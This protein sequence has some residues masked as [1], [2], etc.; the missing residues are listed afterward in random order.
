VSVYF[1]GSWLA[2]VTAAVLLLT[3]ARR[4]GIHLSVSV[5]QQQRPYI[6]V[7]P[8]L[9]YSPL[10]VGLGLPQSP[11]DPSMVMLP[12]ASE[13]PGLIQLNEKWYT[14][15]RSGKGEREET[16]ALLSILQSDEIEDWALQ[17]KFFSGCRQLGIVLEPALIDLFFSIP[18]IDD[19]LDVLLRIGRATKGVLG[20]SL[21][22]LL[23]T[24]EERQELLKTTL[25]PWIVR[26]ENDRLLEQITQIEEDLIL[27]DVQRLTSVATPS[28]LGIQKSFVDFLGAIAVPVDPLQFIE[29]Q[30]RF[31]GGKFVS[32]APKGKRFEFPQSEIPE[33]D[34]DI[35]EWILE[36]TQK[37]ADSVE[38][39]WR[40]LSEQEQ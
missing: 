36:E 39:I 21:A 11:L 28:M 18:D 40:S 23:G 22:E 17:Q 8:A 3:K 6:Q 31:L 34:V 37:G 35:L 33:D 4:F 38:M 15:D 2:S 1:E 32:V 25:A 5:V 14:I 30:Y 12:G 27:F 9:F 13:H 19:R 10:L 20:I 7:P 24:V 29:K 26:C 16:K